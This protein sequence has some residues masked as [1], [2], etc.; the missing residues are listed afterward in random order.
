MAFFS[1]LNASESSSAGDIMRRNPDRF[2]PLQQFS[3]HVMRAESE[4]SLVDREMLGSYVS[5]LNECDYCF[6]S[7]AHIAEAMGLDQDIFGPL[8]E[9]IDTAPVTEKMKPLFAFARKLTKEPARMVQ[10]D[11]D[12]I[13]IAGWNED[14]A[15]DVVVLVAMFNF[16]NRLLDGHGVKA[17]SVEAMKLNGEYI[18][19]NGYLP[20]VEDA[21][22]VEA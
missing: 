1:Y 10:A 8:L 18:S 12:S 14:T 17:P 22:V 20:L 16:A 6:N 15:S 19:E 11:I 9:N 4:L 21:P 5:A 2:G 3:N 7:H 13:T